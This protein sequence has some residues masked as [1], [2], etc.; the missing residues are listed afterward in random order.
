MG[1][2]VGDHCAIGPGIRCSIRFKRAVDL[3]KLNVSVID[4][5]NAAELSPGEDICSLVKEANMPFDGFAKEV[6][7]MFFD[8]ADQDKGG[9]E[10][11]LMLLFVGKG[12]GRGGV[13]FA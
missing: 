3:N 13:M 2:W 8:Q 5:F 6:L 4:T 1:T 9:L 10:L 7:E 12:V 11:L